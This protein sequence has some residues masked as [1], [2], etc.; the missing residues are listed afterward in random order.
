MATVEEFRKRQQGL[1]EFGEFVRD[2][3]DLQAVLDEACRIIADALDVDL[4]KVIEIDRGSNTGLVRAGFGWKPGIVGKK[5][6]DLN[7]HSSEAYAIEKAEP[8][9]TND[10]ALEERFHFPDFLREH[11]VVALVNVPILLPGRKPWGVLQ[12]DAQEPRDFGEE[13]IEFLQ[14]Y[15]MVLGPVVDRLETVNELSATDERFRLVAENARDY[16]IILSDPDD[17][18]TD[19]LGGSEE[20]LG[21]TEQEVLGRSTG[22]LF[23]EE[24]VE[25]GMPEQELQGAREGGASANVRWHVRKDGSRVFLDGHTVSL[26]SP[27]GDLRG[28]L[29]IAQD[30]S[31][32]KHDQERQEVLLAELQHRV[33]NVLAMVRSLVRR[34]V[35]GSSS[36]EAVGEQL[37]GRIDALAR[38]QALLTRALGVGV[39]LETMVRDELVAQAA[40]QAS[41][42]LSGPPL[43]LAPKA[44]EV[45]TLAVHELATN[46]TKY[47][48][49]GREGA[50]LS[51]HWEVDH[52]QEP[53]WLRFQWEESGV[54]I[55]EDRPPRAGFGTQLITRR[56]PYE[57][58][59]FGRIDWGRDGVK[60]AI[61]FPLK[62]GESILDTAGPQAFQS[63]GA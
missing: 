63:A 3:E 16:V 61:E 2:H 59:G 41:V 37:E 33:R 10:I 45:L 44:A 34:T 31:G 49:F 53:K 1:A 26:R 54:K 55:P 32:R 22:L 4:A 60:C 58:Q 42:E 28:F 56:V 19:W 18:I 20:I 35:Q 5:R 51:V 30:V 23:T 38:T 14:T 8:V 47:G 57:L 21:W 40:D 39:D 27:D 62:N 29:K 46:A 7:E 15:A 9:I 43:A 24:D 52:E 36:V 12:V 50:K 17:R 6:V 13:D 48:A 11:G 25:Q